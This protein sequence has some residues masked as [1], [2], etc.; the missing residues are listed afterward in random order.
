M[1]GKMDLTEILF[2][3]FFFFKG[4]SIKK[5]KGI[6]DNMLCDFRH[7]WTVKNYRVFRDFSVF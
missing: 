5:K 3:S 2:F 7:T 6:A 1:D 4:F